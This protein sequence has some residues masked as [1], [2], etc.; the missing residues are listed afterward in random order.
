VPET[1]YVKAITGALAAAMRD[2][3]R[4]FVLGEDVAEGGPYTTTAGLAEEF[5]TDRVRNTP[6]SE[7]AITGVA[8]GAAQSGLRPVLEIMF[9]D[10]VT[11]ALDQLANAAAKAHA[12]SGGQLSVPMVLRTQGG[13]GHRGAAQH[14]QSLE[15]WLTHIPGLKVVMPSTAAD[16]AGLLASAIADP[17]PVVVIENKALYFRREDVSETPAPV[18]IG[19][20]RI[21][22]P[23]RDVTIVA[24]SRMVPEALEAA[25][26]LAQD[27]I[28]AEVID[29]RTLVPL[30]LDTILESVRRTNHLV[31]AHEAVVHGGFGAEIAALVQQEAF[32]DLDA[33]IE[34]VGA[35]FAPIPFSPPL[36][37]AYVPGSDDVVAAAEAA[38]GST[39]GRRTQARNAEGG[40]AMR[41]GPGSSR[42]RS[43]LAVV[44]LALTMSLALA[45]CGG[46]DNG[47]TGTS[48][49]T[50][51]STTAST[52]ASTTA[53]TGGESKC[54]LGNGQKATGQPI[55]LGAIA[56]KQPGTDFSEIPRTSKAYFD[57]V[58]DNGGINGR[59]I[60]YTIETEQTD[61]GQVASLAK[62]LIESDKVLGLVGSTSIIDCAVNH[63]YYESQGYNVIDSGIAP[64]CYTTSNSAPVNMGPRY[65]SDGATQYLIK[66]GVK[67]IVF[68]QS[69]VPGTG[70]IEAG[71]IAIAKDAGVPIES[72]KDNVPIQ[73]ANSIALKL[74]QA[75]GDGG[76]VVLNFTP[77]EALKI[78]Q[79]AEQQGLA[80][81]VKWACSTPCNT[82]FLADALGSSWD[83][84]LFVNAE[85]NLPSADAP[86]SNLY[87]QIL[88]QYAPDIPLGS[89]S[90]MGF[91]EARIA[92]DALMKMQGDFTA[93]T[94]NQ[95][96][97]DVKGF[98]TDIL[99]K[100]WYYGKAP[101]HIPN[102]TDRTV[103]PKEGKMVEQ[104]G[105]TEISAVDPDIAKVRKIEQEQGL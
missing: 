91:V 16:A 47:D 34:R 41:M 45:A 53:S 98:K 99:C 26:R 79:A 10:F 105:C 25:D 85:L 69:N 59:P 54:G 56:T 24:L 37:D 92:T 67:K 52:G 9:I 80:Q 61:P 21:V 55:K 51:A 73:D 94:V 103:T 20:A 104:E 14:S 17:D 89:F 3:P 11:L 60:D 43:A 86:D 90:Q 33:P 32:D 31:I 38:V 28:E 64:E 65:S 63:K 39:M 97:Q 84:Q 5:G 19:R 58:N 35:P 71:P 78:L 95:A 30:D 36:E 48:A 81:K 82:D 13:A 75:A 96:F 22:R 87:R 88:K 70:Y 77:P 46:D 1:T 27:G 100:P 44:V 15:S 50:G 29:P 18:P 74:V 57:C 6:I 72:I 93:K 4:V 40:G 66:Q 42:I 7:A 83:G 2:D 102:N 101:L 12:M 62:K 49:S 23:G 76:G 68:D 8:I